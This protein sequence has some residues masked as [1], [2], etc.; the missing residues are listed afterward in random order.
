MARRFAESTTVPVIKS[1]HEI[2]EI[3]IKYG[4]DEF[5]SGWKEADN[6][7]SIGFVIKGTRVRIIFSIPSK[8]EERFHYFSNG[9]G[10][11]VQRKPAHALKAWED[12]C[13]RM[14][15]SAT[16]VI[17]AKLEAVES[18]ITTFEQEFLPF[19]VMPNGRTIGEALLP[20][21]PDIMGGVRQLENL[22]R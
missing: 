21:L 18:G 8:D 12:E 2:E 5:A 10:G 9:R 15:R 13:K 1:R 3:L 20:Q 16:L 11:Q 14:W 19:I 22:R 7:A 4:A 6:K 17:K